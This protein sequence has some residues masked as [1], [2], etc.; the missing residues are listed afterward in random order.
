[1]L[2]D[3]HSMVVYHVTPEDNVYLITQNGIDPKY[4][5]GKMKASWFVS[6]HNIEWAIIHTSV[7]HHEPIESLVVCA[8]Q[9]MGKDMYRF[10]RPGFYYTFNIHQIESASPALFFLHSIGMGEIENE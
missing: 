4:A 9:V 3:F 6:K 8:V 10:N 1:M 7:G 2:K 5:R